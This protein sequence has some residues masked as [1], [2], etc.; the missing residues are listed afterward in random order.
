MANKKFLLVLCVLVGL[1]FSG[2]LTASTIGG[3]A[4][5]HGL[6]SSSANEAIRGGEIIASY[7]VILGLFDS[8]YEI[9]V[10]AVKKAT[11]EGKLVTS[12]TTSYFGFYAK[13]T[14]YAIKQ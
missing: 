12:V 5:P 14:A 9:Y 13:V 4:D 6:F 3:T 10:S 8:D 11:D 1:C 2:C 7:S